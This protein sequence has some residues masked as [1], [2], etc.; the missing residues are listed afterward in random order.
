MK[1]DGLMASLR[2]LLLYP[3]K[4]LYVECMELLEIV[5]LKMLVIWKG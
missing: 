1:A 5:E 2:D 4:V 3:Q